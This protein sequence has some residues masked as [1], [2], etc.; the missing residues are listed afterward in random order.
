VF[1][2]VGAEGHPPCPEA[3]SA[4]APHKS[5]PGRSYCQASGMFTLLAFVKM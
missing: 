1:I 4:Q 2:H 5:Q 3:S